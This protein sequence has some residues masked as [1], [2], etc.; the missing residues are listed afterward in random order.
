MIRQQRDTTWP[1]LCILLALFVLSAVSPRAWERLARREAAA[2]VPAPAPQ[3]DEPEAIGPLY[4]ASVPPL[5]IPV[6]EPQFEVADR[7]ADAEAVEPPQLSQPDSLEAITPAPSVA[8]PIIERLPPLDAAAIREL[9]APEAE[10]P[11]PSRHCRGP[12]RP[13][14]PTRRADG[15]SPRPCTST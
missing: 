9:A 10:A 11:P 6:V 12:R 8:R 15:P 1:F 3:A 7:A 5:E 13:M 4:L 2:E 14:R